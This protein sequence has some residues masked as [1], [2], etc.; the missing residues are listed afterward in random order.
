MLDQMNRTRL[1]IVNNTGENGNRIVDPHSRLQFSNKTI[2]TK[3]H[4]RLGLM[5]FEIFDF[6]KVTTNLSLAAAK[7]CVCDNRIIIISANWHFLRTII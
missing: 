7:Q 2:F 3:I 6:R 5:I 4:R 1:G